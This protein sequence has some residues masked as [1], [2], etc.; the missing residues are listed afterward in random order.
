[1][2]YSDYIIIKSKSNVVELMIKLSN[3]I[4]QLT[5]TKPGVSHSEQT[6]DIY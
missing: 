4:L 1:M 2:I 3:S 6:F 5:P